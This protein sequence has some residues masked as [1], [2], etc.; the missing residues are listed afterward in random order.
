M[1]TKVKA[2]ILYTE[3]LSKQHWGTATRASDGVEICD[4]TLKLVTRWT[5]CTI[6]INKPSYQC[7]VAC[8]CHLKKSNVG[9]DSG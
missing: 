3:R 5:D 6:T 9:A 8:Q 4:K 7:Y 1:R 2:E